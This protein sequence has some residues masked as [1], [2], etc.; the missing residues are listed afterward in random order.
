M[1]PKDSSYTVHFSEEIETNTRLHQKFDIENFRVYQETRNSQHFLINFY[2]NHFF[3][4][5]SILHQIKFPP[6][7]YLIFF[8]VP[9]FFPTSPPQGDLF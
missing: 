6:L 1:T 4:L 7:A 9:P 3:C 8:M 5:W 2:L